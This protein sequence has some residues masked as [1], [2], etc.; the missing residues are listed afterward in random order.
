MIKK[1]KTKKNYFDQ[2]VEDSIVKY[3]SFP[4]ESLERNIIYEKKIHYA[5]Y[6]LTEN[7]IHTFKF[8]HTDVDNLEDLQFEVIVFLISKMKKFDPS[9]GFKAYSYFGT[10]TKRWLILYNNKNYAKKKET[11]PIEVIEDNKNHSYDELEKT[12]RLSYFIN[13]Y[14]LYCTENIY[15]LFPDEIDSKIADAVLEIFRNRTKFDDVL[16]NK[17]VLYLYIREIINVR[18]PRMT[19]VV[20][21]MYEIF[22]KNYSFYLDNDY[23]NFEYL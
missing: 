7:I 11:L 19:S 18:T 15:T 3:N 17:K 22:K 10:I 14:I 5:F 23:L 16:L 13:E 4:E 9:L 21:R 6:K 8:Y 1:K 12:D 20:K 2:E